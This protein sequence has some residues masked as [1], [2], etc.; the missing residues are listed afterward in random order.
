MD[1]AWF[2]QQIFWLH[3]RNLLKLQNVDLVEKVRKDNFC[4][5]KS[6]WSEQ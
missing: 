4:C 3:S 5:L 6:S 2:L 1:A